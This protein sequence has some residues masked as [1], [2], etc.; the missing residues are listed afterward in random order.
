MAV[1]EIALR[2]V[3]RHSLDFSME[4]WKYAVALKRP[5]ADPNLSAKTPRRPAA[6]A[7]TRASADESERAGSRRRSVGPAG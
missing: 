2:V 1:F 4:M 6:R 7:R 5:V 3:Y